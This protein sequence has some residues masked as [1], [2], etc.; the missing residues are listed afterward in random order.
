M[1]AQRSKRSGGKGKTSSGGPGKFADK[2]NVYFLLVMGLPGSG[3][4]TLSCELERRGAW[5]RVNQDD[6]GDRELVLKTMVR[7]LRRNESVV[8]DRCC[9]HLKERRMWL[10]E[11][12]K[13]G[14]N[15]C[16]VV[17]MD[18]P[19]EECVRRVLERKDHPTLRGG[20]AA[21]G[22][23]R[24]VIE[25]FARG[26]EAPLEREGFLSVQRVETRDDVRRITNEFLA[27]LADSN[28]KAKSSKR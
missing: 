18:T 14:V 16:H 19:L 9:V 28:Q 15:N 26:M 21:E 13:L 27:L 7:A 8:L 2:S 4:S 1:S 5:V 24:E 12:Q 3:K 17:F 11:A 25:R 22:S 10:R 6:Q 20:S 23:S